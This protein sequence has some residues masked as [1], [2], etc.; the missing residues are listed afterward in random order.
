MTIFV[1][2]ALIKVQHDE[3]VV[4]WK[5]VY[6]PLPPIHQKVHATGKELTCGAFEEVLLCV[7]QDIRVT[8]SKI[9]AQAGK[10]D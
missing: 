8:R 6:C 10:E 9:M 4:R 2:A 5:A 1:R 7:N 3:P